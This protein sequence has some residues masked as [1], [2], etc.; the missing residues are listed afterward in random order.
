MEINRKNSMRVQFELV[1]GGVVLDPTRNTSTEE[2]MRLMTQA[3][4]KRRK[5]LGVPVSGRYS[6]QKNEVL[7]EHEE[8]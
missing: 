3:L 2:K 1:Y 5:F 6:T 7:D 8:D 4:Q